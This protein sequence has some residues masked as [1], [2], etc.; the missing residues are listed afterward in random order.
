VDISITVRTAAGARCQHPDHQ[1]DVA[2]ALLGTDT[3]AANLSLPSQ[4]VPYCHTHATMAGRSG[5]APAR[6]ERR[7]RLRAADMRHDPDR[8]RPGCRPKVCRRRRFRSVRNARLQHYPAEGM[9]ADIVSIAMAL[10]VPR[11]LRVLLP[12]PLAG[13]L[14]IWHSVS[15]GLECGREPTLGDR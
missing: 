12:I 15:S 11:L 7:A 3:S 6:R 14:E 8:Q 4:N 9:G 1:L 13:V 2:P 5:R 10:E